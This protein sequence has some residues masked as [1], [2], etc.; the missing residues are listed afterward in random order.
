M[1]NEVNVVTWEYILKIGLAFQSNEVHLIYIMYFLF[2]A[3]QS[4]SLPESQTSFCTIN[5]WNLHDINSMWQKLF[6]IK[7]E[8][9]LQET[10]HLE[11]G[12]IAPRNFICIMA[13]SLLTADF[14]LNINSVLFMLECATVGCRFY[15]E[16]F[17]LESV[18]FQLNDTLVG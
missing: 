16:P 2:Y 3:N 1:S 18:A 11:T 17:W 6:V 4:F 14:I 13:F 15:S 10:C 7:R 9:H 8:Y 12:K 5:L